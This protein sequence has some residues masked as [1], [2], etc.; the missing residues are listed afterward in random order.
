[1]WLSYRDTVTEMQ[2]SVVNPLTDDAN[3]I[4]TG[5]NPWNYGEMVSSTQHCEIRA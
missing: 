4:I 3:A 1:M 5:T 2:C